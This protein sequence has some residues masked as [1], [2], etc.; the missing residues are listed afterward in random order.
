MK[1]IKNIFSKVEKQLKKFSWFENGWEIYNRGDYLQLYK[2]NWH[3]N[4][5]GGVHFETY[6]EAAQIKQKKF[7]ICMHAEESCPSQQQFIQKFLDI[8]GEQIKSWKGYELIGKG[9][10]LCKRELPLN[11]KNLDLRIVE[12]FIRLRKLEITVDRVLSSL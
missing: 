9:Y 7:P 10:S 11:F 4:S 5:Q 2:M 1:D 3:N 6:I 12:E 8:E